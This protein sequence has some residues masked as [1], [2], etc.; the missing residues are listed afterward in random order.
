MMADSSRLVAAWN[1]L[2]VDRPP[3][4]QSAVNCAPFTAF[5]SLEYWCWENGNRASDICWQGKTIHFLMKG[6]LRQGCAEGPAG[7][8]CLAASL[9]ATIILIM[10]L[11]MQKKP[12]LPPLRAKNPEQSQFKGTPRQRL[13]LYRSLSKTVYLR[14]SQAALFICLFISYSANEG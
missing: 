14:W 13:P 5:V 11:D 3:S 8:V 2:D 6:K 1:C 10:K 4:S 12:F 7:L 9:Y